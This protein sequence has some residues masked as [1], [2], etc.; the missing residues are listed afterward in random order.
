MGGQ[1]GAKMVQDGAKMRQDGAK[2][3]EEGTRKKGTEGSKNQE[4]TREQNNEDLYT[5]TPDHP[6]LRPHI[7]ISYHII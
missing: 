6:P 3:E 5:L 7:I 2:M 1:D 4:E